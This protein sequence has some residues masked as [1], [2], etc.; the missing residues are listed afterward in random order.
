MKV[1]SSIQV[2]LAP[3]CEISC[4]DTHRTYGAGHSS[5]KFQIVVGRRRLH[6]V[7]PKPSSKH[8]SAVHQHAEGCE[9]EPVDFHTP[10]RDSVTCERRSP[11]D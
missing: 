5:V 4:L 1:C 7:K 9:H 2:S 3:W 6:V 8:I 11:K 10:T